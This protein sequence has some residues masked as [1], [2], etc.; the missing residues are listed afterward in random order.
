MIVN[1]IDYCHKNGIIHR[2]L[3]PENLLLNKFNEIKIVDFGLGQLI[4]RKSAFLKTACGSP[5]YAAPEMIA[6]KP[7]KG[8]SADIWSIGV[9]LY[10]LLC[11]YLPFEHP[12]TNVLYKKI[13]RGHFESP[14]W[15]SNSAK[16]LLHKLLNTNPITRYSIDDLRKHPWYRQQSVLSDPLPFANSNDDDAKMDDIVVEE[17]IDHDSLNDAVLKQMELIGYDMKKSLVSINQ[18]KHD[19]YYATYHLLKLRHN[20]QSGSTNSINVKSNKS[21][22]M[23]DKILLKIKQKNQAKVVETNQ[24]LDRIR[25]D[26]NGQITS[27]QESTPN[28]LSSSNKENAKCDDEVSKCLSPNSIQTA[29]AIFQQYNFQNL[30]K[31]A[32]TAKSPPSIQITDTTKQHKVKYYN[33]KSH[34]NYNPK[35]CKIK[36]PNQQ[37]QQR[38]STT[39]RQRKKRYQKQQNKYVYVPITIKSPKPKNK[40]PSTPQ[41]NL[42]HHHHFIEQFVQNEELNDQRPIIPK[43]NLSVVQQMNIG[44]IDVSRR[45]SRAGKV[46]GQNKKPTYSLTAREAM[47]EVRKSYLDE[48]RKSVLTPTFHPPPAT[49]KGQKRNKQRS[50]RGNKQRRNKPKKPKNKRRHSYSSYSCGSQTYRSVSTASSAG[51]AKRRKRANNQPNQQKCDLHKLYPKTS[52]YSARA[53]PQRQSYN[54]HSYKN[55]GYNR[56]QNKQ[57]VRPPK[58]ARSGYRG[59]IQKR[60]NKKSARNAMVN[61]PHLN[62][63]RKVKKVVKSSRNGRRQKYAPQPPPQAQQKKKYN[64]PRPPIQQAPVQNGYARNDRVIGGGGKQRE[65][66]FKRASGVRVVKSNQQQYESNNRKRPTPPKFRPKP[67]N[68]KNRNNNGRRRKYNRAKANGYR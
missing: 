52:R 50:K 18:R 31:Q 20:N 51:S 55:R 44:D 38:P 47:R 62:M 30:Q 61:P 26:N 67:P 15:L 17:N 32:M 25:T 10:A 22:A 66:K 24:D 11:G 27:Q 48:L 2:D 5:C 39:N 19:H 59:W 33:P 68:S 45:R 40:R 37:Q 12:N 43:L 3:K 13:I 4:Q 34:R 53:P 57:N 21:V 64:R 23:I 29:A 49:H 65:P 42:L 46:Y 58:S 7:Y 8:Q 16:S 56:N 63:P 9:I 6:G 35:R 28:S 41:Q 14:S 1:G 60:G 36:S 54:D